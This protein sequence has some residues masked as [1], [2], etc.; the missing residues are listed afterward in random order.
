VAAH[1]R[2]DRC[3]VGRPAGRGIE[4]GRDIVEVLGTEDAGRHDRERACV[5]VAGVVEAVDG[6]ATDAERL[7]GTDDAT[8]ELTAP[9]GPS[10]DASEPL[11]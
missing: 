7:A 11:P 9:R 4:D 8:S 10:R 5:V 6:P 1:H 3:E 2:A